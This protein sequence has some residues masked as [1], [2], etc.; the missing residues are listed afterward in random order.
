VCR[1][2]RVRGSVQSETRLRGPHRTCCWV[3]VLG[4]PQD[5]GRDVVVP[6]T[7]SARRW[8]QSRSSITSRLRAQ[9]GGRAH[10]HRGPPIPRTLEGYCRT[11]RHPRVFPREHAARGPPASLTYV[12]RS[13]AIRRRDAD[14]FR[15]GVLREGQGVGLSIVATSSRTRQVGRLTDRSCVRGRHSCRS[16]LV[17]E[18]S[19]HSC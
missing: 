7:E 4:V 12:A 16:E 15:G 10:A 2:R 5:R 9:Q 3:I 1:R 11:S 8:Q 14:R 19:A 18:S 13:R 6:A 17:P